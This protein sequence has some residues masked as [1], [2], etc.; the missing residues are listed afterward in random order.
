[1]PTSSKISTYEFAVNPM[2]KRLYAQHGKT[3]NFL[4]VLMSTLNVKMDEKVRCVKMAGQIAA[5]VGAKGA[6]VV[7]EGYGNPDV[8][9]TAMLV[10]LER[11]GIKTV[12]LSDECT[13]AR[14]QFGRLGRLH[15]ARRFVCHGEQRHVLRKPHQ[16]ILHED[17]C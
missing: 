10:E 15:K 16:R 17:M 1:M 6:V 4:G 13:R 7:E 8:D 3:I 5:S 14:R 11:L 9:Y 12:G 2:I